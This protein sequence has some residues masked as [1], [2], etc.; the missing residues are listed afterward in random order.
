MYNSYFPYYQYPQIQQQQVGF[1]RVQ[2]EN[3]ARLY[4]VPA[5][6]SITFI[7]ENLPYCYVKSVDMSQLDRPKFER[8]KL[9]K[10]ETVNSMPEAEKAPEYALKC[11][12]DALTAKI[13]ELR[14]EIDGLTI[15]KST[16][17]KDIE[18]E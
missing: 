18:D 10:E 1:V 13:E 5:G 3:E 6:Q 2:N 8:Y 11:D 12:V 17:K 16:R 9:V 14:T 4:P 15:R 7:D